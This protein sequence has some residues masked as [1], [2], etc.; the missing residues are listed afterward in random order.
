MYILIILNLD[1][2]CSS[3][4]FKYEYVGIY[5]FV[6]HILVLSSHWIIDNKKY[7]KKE[8]SACMPKNLFFECT[9][10][11]YFCLTIAQRKG[12]QLQK[13]KVNYGW[14]EDSYRKILENKKIT[15]FSFFLRSLI[16]TNIVNCKVTVGL[17]SKGTHIL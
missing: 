2:H 3:S 10:D 15:Y 1:V 17:M 7:A 9:V 6:S 4:E 13:I 14:W 16:S 11:V 5:L 12:S 8:T